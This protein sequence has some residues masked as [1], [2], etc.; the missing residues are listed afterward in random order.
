MPKSMIFTVPFS[1]TMMFAGLMSQWMTS[2]W[3]ANASPSATWIAMSAIVA[4][5]QHDAGIEHV[6]QRSAFEELH[7]DVRAVV[8]L[9]HVVDGDD[10]RMIEPACR[11]RLAREALAKCLRLDRREPES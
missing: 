10:V 1:S 2:F 11:L 8:A 7:R 5:A 3:C 6:A 9:P 4:G